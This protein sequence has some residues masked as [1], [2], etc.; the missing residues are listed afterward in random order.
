MAR[1][2]DFGGGI[3]ALA[4]VEEAANV[5]GKFPVINLSGGV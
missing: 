1:G 4:L 5:A 2:K 3:H